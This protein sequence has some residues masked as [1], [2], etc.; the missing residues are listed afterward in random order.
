MLT[1]LFCLS[2]V[3]ATMCWHEHTSGNVTI[4]HSHFHSKA[5]AEEGADDQTP[6]QLELISIAGNILFTAEIWQPEISCCFTIATREIA[7]PVLDRTTLGHSVHPSL[8]GP[9]E[10]LL[11]Y[12]A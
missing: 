5:H 12:H 10:N 11:P 7:M 9:P 4:V 1:V 2:Y 3:N 8:R 6:E